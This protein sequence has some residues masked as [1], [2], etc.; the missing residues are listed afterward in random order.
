MPVDAKILERVEKLLRLAAPASHSTEH[1]RTSAALEAARLF[2][3]HNLIVQEKK[4]PRPRKPPRSSYYS[5]PSTPPM[6]Y[7]SWERTRS[8]LETHCADPECQG[9]IALGEKVWLRHTGLKIEC[10]HDDWPDCISR[11]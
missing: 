8:P 6:S 10:L 7:P 4:K 9:D 1:E 3:E 11:Q 5:P 2:S